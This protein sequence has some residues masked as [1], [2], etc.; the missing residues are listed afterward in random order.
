MERSTGF[1]ISGAVFAVVLV[2]TL[3]IAGFQRCSASS[4]VREMEKDTVVVRYYLSDTEDAKL[5][6]FRVDKGES[7][8]IP[9]LPSKD[10][11]RFAGLYS[12]SDWHDATLYVNSDGNSVVKIEK[13]IVLYPAFT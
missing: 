8:T 5:Y 12:S 7:F 3:I 13:D 1:K 2:F 9:E 6:Y 11:F 4:N 10:G